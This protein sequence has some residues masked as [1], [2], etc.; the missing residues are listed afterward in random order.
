[1]EKDIL[2]LSPEDSPE[3]VLDDK[4]L[5]KAY[6]LVGAAEGSLDMDQTVVRMADGGRLTLDRAACDLVIFVES[7][8]CALEVEGEAHTLGPDTIVFLPPRHGAALCARGDAKFLF[9]RSPEYAEENDAPLRI[10]SMYDVEPYAPGGHAD[11]ANRYLIGPEFGCRYFE[12]IL[13][14]FGN[15][16]TAHTHSHPW[17]QASYML[18]GVNLNIT[19]GVTKRTFPGELKYIPGDVVHQSF[20]ESEVTKF[21]LFYAPPRRN[22]GK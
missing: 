16:G 8:S 1:M 22:F 21:L 18:E 7:G 5:V 19:N 13:G 9:I 10:V 4:G 6:H 3:Q 2:I 14:I 17:V 20:G 11:T 12:I 15:T